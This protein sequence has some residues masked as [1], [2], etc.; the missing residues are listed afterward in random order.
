AIIDA[1]LLGAAIKA[2]GPGHAAAKTYE[3]QVRPMAD[4]VTLANR[5]NG[6]PDAIMQMAE[7]RCA[8]D[9]ARL[10]DVL[11]MRERQEHAESFKKLA[12]IRVEDTNTQAPIIA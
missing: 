10:D 1:R 7:D 2:Q 12:R 8:G 11:P 9:F 5:G 6:G 3:D 4:A